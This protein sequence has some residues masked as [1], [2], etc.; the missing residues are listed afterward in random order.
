MVGCGQVSPRQ[1][2]GAG[3]KSWLPAN[4]TEEEAFQRTQEWSQSGFPPGVQAQVLVDSPTGAQQWMNAVL[5]FL[6]ASITVLGTKIL[7]E[8][9][10]GT[11]GVVR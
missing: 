10:G 7:E 8:S 3:N 11:A 2:W 5:L 6:R 1:F 4:P 9:P